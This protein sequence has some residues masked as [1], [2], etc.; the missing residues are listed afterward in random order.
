[1][2]ARILVADDEKNVRIFLRELL[3]SEDFRVLDAENGTQALKIAA[4]VQP[5]LIIL[6]V[7]LPDAN[8][9]DLIV[10]LKQR[11][12]NAQ[13]II[14]TALGTI[15]N[16]VTSMKAGA[17]DFITKPFD[18]DSISLAVHRC[19]EFG[20]ISRE[21]RLLRRIQ[22]ENQY[23]QEFIGES[24]VIQQI[25]GRIFKLTNTDVPVLITG[26]TGTGKN[27][28][29]HQ[30]HYQLNPVES[31]LVYVNCATL[32]EH[33]FESELFGHEKGSFTGAFDRKIG[34]V[35]EADGGT[36]ILDEISEI[37]IHIQAKLLSFLQDQQFFRLGSNI[38]RSVRVR[39]IALTNKRL[40]EEISH[41]RFRKDLY[42]RLNVICFDIPPLRQRKEDI[43]PLCKHFMELFARRYGKK[44]DALKPGQ[45]QQLQ[46]HPWPGNTRELKNLLEQAY[47]YSDD[48]QLALD[49]TIL[50]AQHLETPRE[51]NLKLGLEQHE[52]Q[53]ISQALARNGGNRGAT[54]GELGI[55]VRTLH[56]RL[57]YYDIQ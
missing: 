32:T 33:L 2:K 57:S 25:R 41:G 5:Q 14:I 15:Q 44:V 38:Q 21:N 17:F 24:E 7:K 11:S 30:I 45:Y 56:Y 52:K 55:S 50:S 19:L 51:T 43:V 23:F 13:V 37:P 26:E 12:P 54:A 39:I 48:G 22:K 31:P 4:E 18:V 6:D 46:S 10:P 47:I 29:A 27:I 20:Q 53:L 8:G 1:M 40:E 36:L 3:E 49:E 16:A 42:Y 34:R 28:L 9:T 35:E